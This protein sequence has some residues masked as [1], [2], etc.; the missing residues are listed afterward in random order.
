MIFLDNFDQ[1]PKIVEGR[2]ETSSWPGT[3]HDQQEKSAGPCNY[4][5]NKLSAKIH[6]FTKHYKILFVKL[7]RLPLPSETDFG[8]RYVRHN[9]ANGIGQTRNECTD[10]NA[11]EYQTSAGRVNAT[12]KFFDGKFA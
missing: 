3:D 7:S 6:S 12:T 11:I 1:D 10:M 9:Q 5:L 2:L 8:R 4:E